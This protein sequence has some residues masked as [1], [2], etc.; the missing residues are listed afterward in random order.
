[1]AGLVCA[2]TGCTSGVVQPTSPMQPSAPNAPTRASGTIVSTLAGNPISDATIT[3]AGSSATT[4]TD[5]QGRFTV[6]LT[7][8]RTAV[9]VE[10]AGFLTRETNIWARPAPT[11]TTRDGI[12]IDLI[13][14]RPPFSLEFYRQYV[15]DA[16]ENPT[17]LK[18]L[19]RWTVAPR[20]YLRTLTEDTGRAIPTAMLDRIQ[21]IFSTR[22]PELTGGQ[23]AAGGFDRGAEHRRANGWV[24]LQSYETVIPGA[25]WAQGRS[26]VAGDLIEILFSDI[27]SPEC[28]FE[29]AGIAAHELVHIMG[30]WHTGHDEY[31]PFGLTRCGSIGPVAQYHAAI[32]Y[33]RPDGN[34]DPDRDPDWYQYFSP[35][36][37]TFFR[38][39]PTLAGAATAT[40]AFPR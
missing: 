25:P 16:W 2:A 11:P 33:A 29:S 23:F 8:S 30:F 34:Q 40:C 12:T 5:G 17:N 31:G 21:Q 13:D 19:R 4:K 20:F 32:A 35:S 9:I 39:R 15:R 24:L 18:P 1:V 3:V 26:Q 38:D 14:D 22:V 27:P 37:L 28:G 6:D 10:A 7:Q 36:G